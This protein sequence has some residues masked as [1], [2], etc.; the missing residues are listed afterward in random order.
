MK[1]I[2]AIEISD[3]YMGL[4]SPRNNQNQIELDMRDDVEVAEQ[5]A[6]DFDKMAYQNYIEEDGS[7]TAESNV[8]LNIVIQALEQCS[9][10]EP[11]HA[12]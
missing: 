4:R 10:I 1:N 5:G 12:R 6:L 9:N 3:T 7:E 2:Q 11:N 8:Y